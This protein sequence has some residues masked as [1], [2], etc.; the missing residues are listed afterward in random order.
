MESIAVKIHH[1]N[2]T[3]LTPDTKYYYEV[4]IEGQLFGSGEFR[5]APSTYK[6]FTWGMISDTQQN[7]GQGHYY[8][9]ARVLDTKNYAFVADVGD[10]VD[11]GDEIA[12][13]NNFFTVS[14][15]YFD[16]IP[17]VPVEG[18]HDAH[19]PSL[20]QNYYIN[21]VNKSQEQFYYSFNWSSVHFQI[22]SFPYGRQSEI[23]DAQMAWI[24]QDLANAQ[25][26][27]FRVVLFHC[28]II[29]SSFFGRNE[30]LIENVQPILLQY[31]VTAVIHGHEH[32]FER[33]HI[34]DMMYMILGGGGAIQDVGLRPQPEAEV[35][36]ISPCYTEVYATASSLTFTT[37]SLEGDILDSYTINA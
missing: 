35:L 20:F 30:V 26:M 22:C 27:P 3:S 16:T 9:T 34:G 32:H 10:L 12:Y 25:S 29:G 33:G 8:R 28:P 17:F 5:T 13:Y 11:E 1:V 36:T 14:S 2:L 18:N 24:K 31:N 19:Q 6:P 23:T 4:R 7:L 37:L 15:Q 21:K